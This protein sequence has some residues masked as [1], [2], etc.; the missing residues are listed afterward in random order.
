M[1][2]LQL[3]LQLAQLGRVLQRKI[4]KNIMNKKKLLFIAVLIVAG[5]AIPI[6]VIPLINSSISRIYIALIMIF[7]LVYAVVAEFR[8]K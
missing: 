6:Y 4:V 3:E 1:L 5:I 7:V 8:K 2:A